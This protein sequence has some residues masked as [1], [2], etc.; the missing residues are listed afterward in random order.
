M[1]SDYSRFGVVVGILHRRNARWILESE[2]FSGGNIRWIEDKGWFESSFMVC[3][4]TNDVKAV[5]SRID[6]Y[7]KTV[8]AE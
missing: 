7:I 5:K 2:K 8:E 3:G 6:E 4:N 1:M